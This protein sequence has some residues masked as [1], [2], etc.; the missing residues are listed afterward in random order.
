MIYH[1]KPVGQPVPEIAWYKADKRLMMS[2][3]DKRIFLNWELEED[4]Y[5][6]EIRNA[7][8]EDTEDYT[9]EARNP[10]GSA[11]AI[12]PVIVRPRDEKPKV[13]PKGQTAEDVRQEPG[14]FPLEEGR[15]AAPDTQEEVED[16]KPRILKTPEGISV[17]E[18]EV[19]RLT[20]Q[21]AG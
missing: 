11:T 14:A 8:L 21:V 1:V 10:G 13:I 15:T 4:L 18:G 2:K 19:I 5:V 17:R 6:L 9:I 16:L 20:C 7:E 12:V 3:R